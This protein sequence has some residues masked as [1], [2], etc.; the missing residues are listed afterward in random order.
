M[1]ARGTAP[2]RP[3]PSA[4]RAAVRSG[5]APAGASCSAGPRLRRRRG[6]QEHAGRRGGQPEE[7]DRHQDH[8]DRGRRVTAAV[9]AAGD[10]LELAAEDAGR[11]EGGQREDRR[12][13]TAARSTAAAACRRAS[14]DICL[15]PYL[16]VN[17]P[18]PMNALPFAAACAITCSSTPASATGAPKDTPIARMPM[19]STLEYASSRLTSRCPNTYS[20]GQQQRRDPERQQRVPREAAA[21]AR[22]R[23]LVE[24]QDGVEAGREQR[25]RTAARTPGSAPPSARPAAR[26]APGTGRPWCRSRAPRAGTPAGPASSAGGSPPGSAAGWRGCSARRAPAR[27]A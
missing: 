19:C 8:Q 20:D 17:T 12:A 16:T 13:G 7:R 5:F 3:R 6:C 27:P 9:Q 18:A 14:P 11:R 4:L 10:D 23:D 24:A 1:P 21:Q 26:C 25:H 15:V 2:R 22:G